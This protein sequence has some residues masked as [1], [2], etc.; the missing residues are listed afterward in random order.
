VRLEN[1]VPAVFGPEAAQ[2]MTQ[3]MLEEWLEEQVNQR[4]RAQPHQPPPA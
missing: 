2:A 1:F 3:E 4:L